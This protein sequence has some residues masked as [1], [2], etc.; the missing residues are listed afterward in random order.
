MISASTLSDRR[1]IWVFVLGVVAVTGGVI[2]HAP[3]FWMGRHTHFVLYGMPIG[4]DMILGMVGIVGGL[5]IAAYGLLPGSSPPRRRLSLL[6][7][8]TRRFRLPTGT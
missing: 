2:L 6:R 3:M 4:W 8:K 1:G 7:P 5:G